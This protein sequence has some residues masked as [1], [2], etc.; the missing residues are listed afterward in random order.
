[1]N[2][3]LRTGLSEGVA[4]LAR[5]SSVLDRI[6]VF[7]VADGDTGRNLMLSLAPLARFGL[8]DQDAREV[9]LLAA[10]GNSGN[11]ASQF[12]SAL[13]EVD[14]L[15]ALPD[16]VSSGCERARGAVA[17]P[18]PGTM[19]TL[20]D[21]LREALGEHPPVPEGDWVGSVVERLSDSVLGTRTQQQRLE[22]AGVVDA[23]ALGMWIVL[24]RCFRTVQ[25]ADLEL[26]TLAQR[27]GDYLNVRADWN[28]RP[29]SGF[30]VDAVL[31]LPE[32]P[33][34][35][36]SLFV[37]GGAFQ[38]P[39]G[40]PGLSSLERSGRGE[41]SSPR[42]IPVEDFGGSE[43]LPGPFSGLGESTVAMTHGGLLKV[44]LHGDDLE[45]LRRSLGALGEV[46]HFASDDLGEQWQSLESERQR[47]RV[48]LVTDA[49]GTFTAD[50]AAQ[51]GVTVLDSYILLGEESIPESRLP[52]QRL[53]S[54][55]S[56]GQRITTSQASTAER[57]ARYR[58]AMETGK[59]VLYLAV[60]SVFTGNVET[61][62]RFRDAEG[63]Q[64]R[65]LVIDSGAASGRLGILAL[66]TA[67]IVGRGA[68]LDQAQAF[69]Q[70]AL[71]LAQEWVFLDQLKYLARGGRLSRTA[72]FFGDTLRMKPV[73]SPRPTGAEKV[74]VVRHARDQ[75]PFLVARLAE[76]PPEQQ[77]A[78]LLLQYSDNEARLREEILPELQRRYPKAEIL[79]R[80]LSLTSGVHMGPG[81]WAVA[82]L[83]EIPCP[84]LEPASES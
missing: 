57:H 39:L 34:G 69:A 14:G 68:T 44:H 74:G 63:C 61:A 79:V 78:L 9:L 81:T 19:L 24:E 45:E 43:Q 11:I 46:V 75:L 60:G 42:E 23:G 70:S 29:E 41:G 59:P 8:A 2:Q 82:T 17:D 65:F 37:Q 71:E 33:E 73:I 38:S 49:A 56:A 22:Q 4:E 50:D 16:A 10:R 64:D 54:A 47:V 51:Y 32:G 20:F 48:H 1:M 12:L 77:P 27:F 28:Q 6:N 53:Y 52:P 83:P 76:L 7:P 55:M 36:S 35:A 40:R 72:A 26:P 30:C 25:E 5:W 80:R 84:N 21:A 13:L 31:R 67:R 18:Q 15:S 66:A 58:A 3:T 62:E